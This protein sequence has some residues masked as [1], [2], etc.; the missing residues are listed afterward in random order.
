MPRSRSPPLF[1]LSSSKNRKAEERKLK[2]TYLV[3]EDPTCDGINP[4]WQELAGQEYLTFVR[5]G[6]AAGRYFVKLENNEDNTAIVMEATRAN[7]LAWRKEK[8]HRAYLNTCAK[9]KIIFP[10]HALDSD[11]GG[12]GEE[13]L[14]DKDNDV[15]SECLAAMTRETLKAALASLTAD[16]YQLI[17]YLY[18]SDKLTTEREY[19]TISGIPQKTI[20]DRKNRILRKLKKFFEK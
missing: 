11:S 14:E 8:N 2:T 9:G 7:F 18:L 4:S 1:D 15:L 16:E 10:Y 5:S 3:W 17:A 19:S 20:N 6:K 13:I 12:Y